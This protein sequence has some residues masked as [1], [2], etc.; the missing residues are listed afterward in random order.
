MLG[1]MLGAQLVALNQQTADSFFRTY[2]GR[3]RENGRCGYV[4]KP[5]YLLSGTA[6]RPIR[7]VVN[8]LGAHQLP[9]PANSTQGE[10]IDPF[11]VATM[12]GAPGDGSR[13]QTRTVLDNGFCPLWNEVHISKLLSWGLKMLMICVLRLF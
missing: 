8:I 13:F 2:R 11:V 3:F 9:K 12:H 6:N 7:L 10:I 1:W 4:L 5:E